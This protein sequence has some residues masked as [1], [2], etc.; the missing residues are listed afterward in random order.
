MNVRELIALTYEQPLAVIAREKLAIGER[1]ARA[2][3]KEANCGTIVGQ[4]GWRYNGEDPSELDRSIYDYADQVRQREN[5]KR[6]HA[7]NVTS[8]DGLGTVRKRHSFDLD[9]QLVKD[10]KLKSVEDDIHLYLAV[11]E[12][13]RN[14]LKGDR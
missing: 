1:T 6:R 5:E 3:L 14:Y 11:E 13:I 9:V 12:A 10:L 8:N 7:A 2:A 4:P